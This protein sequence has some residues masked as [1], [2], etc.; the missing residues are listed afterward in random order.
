MKTELFNY[1]LPPDLIAYYPLKNR[2][3]AKM[4]VFERKTQKITHARFADLKSFLPSGAHIF[5]NNT[6]VVK[7][8]LYGKNERGREQ[9]IFFLKPSGQ[10]SFLVNIRGKIRP[11][12]A[13]DLSGGALCRVLRL[14]EDGTRAV[15]FLRGE[16]RLDYT[17]L[18]ELLERAGSV[19]LPPYIKRK[20]E[21]SD[22]Q[23]YETVFAKIPGS[24]A[25]PTASLHF[26]RE[27]FDEL[28][29]SFSMHELTLNIGAGT[30]K[31]ITAENILEHKMHAEAYEIPD[32][33]AR[34]ISERGNYI[35]A[36]GTTALRTIETFARNGA[37]RGVSELFLHPQNPPIRVNALLTNFHLPKSSL[38]VL[39]ASLVGVQTVLDLYR[40]AIKEKYRFFS[41]G[42]CMLIL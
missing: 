23:D 17:E 34:V 42:D 6:K 30:F 20:E 26:D 2:P 39:V 21:Q 24:V 11:G 16:K 32:K 12:D 4:L 5:I 28:A 14:N 3:D 31:P 13:L 37:A 33:S 8:R 22:A 19:P 10:N 36:I 1:E 40:L 15:E 27:M 35:L 9:E 18:L 41:Y 38:I 25:A 29:K 7:A